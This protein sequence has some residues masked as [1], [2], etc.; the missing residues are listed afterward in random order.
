MER[1][2]NPSAWEAGIGR[3]EFKASLIYRVLDSQG[4]RQTLSQK[5]N[6]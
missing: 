6:K 1:I 3:S 4:Y 2:F 5:K